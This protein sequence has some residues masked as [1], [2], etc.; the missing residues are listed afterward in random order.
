MCSC[1]Y[2]LSD[3]PM[4][5]IV[6]I[7]FPTDSVTIVTNNCRENSERCQEKKLLLCHLHHFNAKKFRYRPELLAL[8]CRLIDHHR[9]LYQRE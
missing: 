5:L 8:W 6:T 3:T 4:L 1:L 9:Y 2:H 7:C